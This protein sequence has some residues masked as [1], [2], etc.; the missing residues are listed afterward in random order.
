MYFITIIP[1]IQRDPN[2]LLGPLT[3]TLEN[4]GMKVI[5]KLL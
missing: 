2:K 1:G 5:K 3:P 4:F